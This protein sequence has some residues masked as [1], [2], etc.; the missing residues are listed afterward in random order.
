MLRKNNKR[1]AE[2]KVTILHDS[3]DCYTDEGIANKFKWKIDRILLFQKLKQ[4]QSS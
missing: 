3:Q 1:A 2:G 4:L